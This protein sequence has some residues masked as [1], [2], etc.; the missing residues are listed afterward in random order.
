[1]PGVTMVK[2]KFL[3]RIRQTAIFIY[4]V[5][6]FQIGSHGAQGEDDLQLLI[7]LPLA[8]CVLQFQVFTTITGLCSVGVQPRTSR[9]PVTQSS[10]A[11]LKPVI[12]PIH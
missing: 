4:L 3:E 11:Q 6:C 8:S 1:M 10:T 5:L 12:I 7:L 2:Y 9:M